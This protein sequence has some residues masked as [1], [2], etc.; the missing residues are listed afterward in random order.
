MDG[1]FS[2]CVTLGV[3]PIIRCP[4]GGAAEHLASALDAKLRD[5]LKSR[6]NLF[7]EGVLGLSASLSRPLLCL[8]DR[9]FDLT[10]VTQHAWTYKPLV[11]DVLGLRLNRVALQAE[12]AGPGAG[13]QAAGEEEG[14]GVGGKMWI[15]RVQ[16][17]KKGKCGV[18]ERGGGGVEWSRTGWGAGGGGGAC[19]WPRRL[20]ASQD[21]VA[22]RGQRR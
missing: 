17:G 22:L 2:V 10:A 15:G 21:G 19:G 1:L 6:T 16:R 4:R 7:S 5:A 20:R 9:N 11:Q 18:W 8:F 3:V 13:A 14:G 12:A